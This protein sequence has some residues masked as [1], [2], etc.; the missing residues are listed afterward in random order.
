MSDAP[1]EEGIEI[2]QDA[3]LLR[4]TR[5]GDGDAFGQLW[6]R[7]SAAALRAA[8]QFG[9]AADPEDLVADAYARV[10]SAVRA[11]TGPRG[12]FRPYLL[13]TIRDLAT[14]MGRSNLDTLDDL[15]SV[16]E[17]DYPADPDTALDHSLTAK[18]FRSLHERWQTVLWYTAVEGMSPLEASGLLGLS[19]NSTA[20]LAHRAR[21]G[22]H[23]AWI[24][25]Q[26]NDD[27]SAL[28]CRWMLARMSRFTRGELPTRDRRRALA[29]LVTCAKCLIVSEEIDDLSSHLAIVMIPLLLGGAAGASYLAAQHP[30]TE[31]FLTV[32]AVP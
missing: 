10:L 24:E 2:S 12:A 7:H 32:T 1:S 14:R 21:D 19:A 8:Q 31:V 9:D 20:A 22:L 15:D 3:A 27:A 30:S 11:G 29:H 25:A 26:V 17:V 18:A 16:A 23:Q 6:T 28:E 13:V 5:G 4:K